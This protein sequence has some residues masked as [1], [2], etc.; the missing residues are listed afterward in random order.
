MVR[1]ID[2]KV[3]PGAA[4]ANDMLLLVLLQSKIPAI[5]IFYEQRCAKTAPA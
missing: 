2:M 4:T 3:T 5:S 1:V